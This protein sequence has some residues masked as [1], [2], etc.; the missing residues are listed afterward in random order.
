MDGDRQEREEKVIEAV[1]EWL[2][3]LVTPGS[4]ILV[5]CL[6]PKEHD[7]AHFQVTKNKAFVCR[8]TEHQEGKHRNDETP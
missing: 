5:T 7:G 8:R 2:L 3:D 4:A 1:R 6:D